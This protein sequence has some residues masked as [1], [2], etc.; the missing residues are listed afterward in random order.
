MV[1]GV[2]TGNGFRGALGYAL[3]DQKLDELKA[4]QKPE[5][6][7][8]N[9]VYGNARE[10][11]R[12]MRFVANGNSRVSVPVMHFYVSFDAKENLKESQRQKAVK[13]VLKELGVTDENHQYL[14]VKHN[15]AKNPH[16]H[17]IINKVDLDGKKLNIGFDGKKE[18]F[19]ANRCH[20]IADKIEQEQGLKRTEG[21][22]I[23]YDPN[24]TKGYRKLSK[25]ELKALEPRDKKESISKDP[26]KREQEII[27][28]SEVIAALQNKGIRSPEEFKTLLEQ[29]GIDV[30][31]MEN[32]NGISGVSF[33]SDTI[34][35]KGSQIGAKWSDINKVLQENNKVL[36]ETKTITRAEVERNLRTA[37]EKVASISVSSGYWVNIDH[38]L[39]LRGL[40]RTNQGYSYT[41]N[42]V[43]LLIK[44]DLESSIRATVYESDN[45]YSQ[46]EKRK[47]YEEQ[48]RNAKP[49]EIK[50]VPLLFGKEIREK[51]AEAEIYN[52]RLEQEKQKI[53]LNPV[54]EPHQERDQLVKDFIQNALKSEIEIDIRAEKQEKE[55]S[56][57]EQL[58][59][60]REKQEHSQEQSESRGYS[61]S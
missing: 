12:Q 58:K 30:R 45:V 25:E 19:I 23:I 9:N 28:K 22:K 37:L 2:I 60:Q 32:R 38:L 14:V 8:Q 57:F 29:K 46:Y 36:Q 17:L 59:A 55:L 39:K 42:D 48:V 13:G 3:K 40:V 10:M 27:I 4:D 6:I 26:H 21:R 56:P 15:D 18:E 52:K 11:A 24:S 47:A 49:M 5:I 44:T 20:V 43:N 50:K 33:K 51:N 53:A 34:S 1:V 31:F 41:V 61:R 7:T 16:Y 54:K 35:V